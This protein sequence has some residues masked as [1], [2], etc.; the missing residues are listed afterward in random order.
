MQRWTAWWALSSAS[1]RSACW[2]TASSPFVG[3]F[4]ATA[5]LAVIT[6][7][8]DSIAGAILAMAIAQYLLGRRE[9]TPP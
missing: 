7:I 8:N 3:Q 9:V 2:G 1:P 5:P 6:L 4:A